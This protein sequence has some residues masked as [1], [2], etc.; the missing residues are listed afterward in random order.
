L[1][2]GTSYFTF[3]TDLDW[4]MK[5]ARE[6]AANGRDILVLTRRPRRWLERRHDLAGIDTLHFKVDKT[7]R[8]EGSLSPENI[9]RIF[10][11]VRDFLD[12]NDDALVVF[13]GAELLAFYNGFN[14]FVK[15]LYT[16]NDVVWASGGSVVFLIDPTT[17]HRRELHIIQKELV[18]LR[19][20]KAEVTI[21]H[22]AEG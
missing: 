2:S 20:P 5:Q 6:Q 19:N 10:T 4:L 8:D 22:A 18:E 14:F 3:D 15:L 13:D 17:F 1:E 11:Q 9:G 7:M 21:E 16:I 12:R